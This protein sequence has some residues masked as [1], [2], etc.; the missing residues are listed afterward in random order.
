MSRAYPGSIFHFTSRV[1][2]T[3]SA[4]IPGPEHFGSFSVQNRHKIGP[5]STSLARSSQLRR[6]RVDRLS[7]QALACLAYLAS[8]QPRSPCLHLATTARPPS[9]AGLLL[10]G[11][12]KAS[13]ADPR[14]GKPSKPRPGEQA[15]PKMLKFGKS[16]FDT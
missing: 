10:R 12:G 4:N 14:R 15:D 1:L 13:E 2:Q 11:A 7:R 16:C 5:K 9:A 3:V 8:Y 6:R